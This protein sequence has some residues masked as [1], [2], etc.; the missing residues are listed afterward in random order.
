MDDKYLEK[1]EGMP[2]NWRTNMIYKR[3]ADNEVVRIDIPD[4]E[5][6]ENDA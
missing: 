5:E 2:E 3:T 1:E 4:D 6:V